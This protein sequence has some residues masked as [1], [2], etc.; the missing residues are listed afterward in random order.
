MKQLVTKPYLFFICLALMSVIFS[1]T[2]TDTTF[3]LYLGVLTFQISYARFCTIS[4]VFFLLMSLNYFLLLWSDKSP[5]KWLTILHISLQ[6]FALILFG[7]VGYQDF[8]STK[9]NL[10]IATI[11]NT[12][13]LILLSFLIFLVSVFV[14]LINF[15]G[16]LLLKED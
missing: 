5:K 9:N 12:N 10:T 3:N 1:F 14:H 13:A 11:N 16:S 6:I 8:S 4:A 7:F 15:F 2:I